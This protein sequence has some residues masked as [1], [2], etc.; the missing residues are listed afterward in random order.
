VVYID[1]IPQPSHDYFIMWQA[2]DDLVTHWMDYFNVKYQILEP[3][4]RKTAWDK[5]QLNNSDGTKLLTMYDE[6]KRQPLFELTW[7]YSKQHE[8][9]ATFKDRK[10]KWKLDRYSKNNSLIRDLKTTANIQALEY[11]IKW[12]DKYWYIYQ[13]AFYALLAYI[14]DKVECDFILDIV[15]KTDVPKY[16]WI[17]IPFDYLKNYF[18]IIKTDLD[19]FIFVQESWDYTDDNRQ[20]A[21]QSEYYP[22]LSA[23]IQKDFLTIN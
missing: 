13:W 11:D 8:I 5:I 19:E 20:Y 16:L 9:I 21:L 10:I 22:H 18:P 3:R 17:R 15:E 4:E 7:E 2:L 12:D 14:S 23:S 6:I 1:W